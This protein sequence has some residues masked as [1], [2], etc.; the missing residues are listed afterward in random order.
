MLPQCRLSQQAQ[1]PEHYAQ[2]SQ[3]GDKH[4]VPLQTP[5][6]KANAIAKYRKSEREKGVSRFL[7][8]YLSTFRD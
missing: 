2:H 1:K 4:D 3:P 7:V 8:F 5:D 6:Q